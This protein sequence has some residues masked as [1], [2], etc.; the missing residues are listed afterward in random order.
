MAEPQHS[1]EPLESSAQVWSSPAATWTAVPIFLT[2]TGV[3]ELVS[4]PFPSWPSW[5][6]PQQSTWPLDSSAHVLSEP[7]LSWIGPGV[8]ET[9]V[10]A[11][12]FPSA[13]LAVSTSLNATSLLPVSAGAVCSRSTMPDSQG[14]LTGRPA[15]A[16]FED[17]VHSVAFETVAVRTTEP[18]EATDAGAALKREIFGF[19]PMPAAPAV[20]HKHAAVARST[21]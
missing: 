1:T 8:T 3:S 10:L 18:P 5:L 15:T 9:V 14:K 2:T 17:S 19:E 20:T 16:S 7:A 4:L 12:A 6:C 21:A 13:P 11:T